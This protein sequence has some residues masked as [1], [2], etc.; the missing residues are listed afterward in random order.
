MSLSPPMSDGVI[1]VAKVFFFQLHTFVNIVVTLVYSHLLQT[2][3]QWKRIP[4]PNNAQATICGILSQSSLSMG[5]RVTGGKLWGKITIL[6]ALSCLFS[7]AR[8]PH[9]INPERNDLRSL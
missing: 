2:V 9:P 4:I 1:L 6:N 3:Y 5:F 8:A 7:K